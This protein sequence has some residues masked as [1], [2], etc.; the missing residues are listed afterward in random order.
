MITREGAIEKTKMIDC[1]A[2]Y[3]LSSIS[4]RVELLGATHIGAR[5]SGL[6]AMAIDIFKDRIEKKRSPENLK[7]LYYAMISNAYLYTNLWLPTVREK[8]R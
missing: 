8:L 5:P 1:E 4:A 3:W 6:T 2:R 7:T